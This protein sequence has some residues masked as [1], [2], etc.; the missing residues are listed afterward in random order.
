[1]V[2][3][4]GVIEKIAADRDEYEQVARDQQMPATE[5]EAPGF[6]AAVELFLDYIRS[7]GEDEEP[8]EP[9]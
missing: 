9:V 3:I 7:A 1:M 8:A 4:G 5:A 6:E 2:P